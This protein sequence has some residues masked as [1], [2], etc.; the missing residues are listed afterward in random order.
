MSMQIKIYVN[1]EET[2]LRGKIYHKEWGEGRGSVEGYHHQVLSI[3]IIIPLLVL[4]IR[5]LLLIKLNSHSL[6]A[7][8]FSSGGDWESYL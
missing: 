2:L 7:F 4:H 1:A 6:C 5:I 8:N 3:Y